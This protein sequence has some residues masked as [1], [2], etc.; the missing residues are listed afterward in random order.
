MRLL[1]TTQAVDLDDPYLGFFHGWILEFAKHFERIDVICLKKGRHQLPSHV[2]VHS[3]GKEEGEN[4]LKYLFRFYRYYTKIFFSVRVDYV[5]YH[6]G[7]VYNILGS[8][9]FLIR[10]FFNTKFFWWK[11]HG[12]VGEWKETLALL[13]VEHVYTAG[14]KSFDRKTSKVRVVGHAIDTIRFTN[15]TDRVHNHYNC[16]MV[17]RLVPIK[18]IEVALRACERLKDKQVT[19]TLVGGADDKEYENSLRALV[20]TKGLATKVRFEGS[21]VPSRVPHYYEQAGIL[22][23]PAYEAGFDKVVLEAMAS[24]VIPLTSIPSFE[25]V[26]GPFG[27]FIEKVNDKEYA[28][29]IECVIQMSEEERAKLQN[30]LRSI[31]LEKHSL[32][33]LPARIF[34]L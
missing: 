14:N 12:K 16:L 19:L 9:F 10:S 5:F 30:E 11:T 20:Q 17:G 27:L 6:M 34:N 4:R 26:L 31:V 28:G 23:H 21:Q 24:G 32:T 1:V 15:A 18:K 8:P 13:C 7:A 2:Y 25:S 22:L 33:T 29:A 3:L